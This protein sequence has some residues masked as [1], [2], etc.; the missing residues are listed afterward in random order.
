M[1]SRSRSSAHGMTDR[2]DAP[3]AEVVSGCFSLA[4]SQE[5]R[6]SRDKIAAV[7]WG[8]SRCRTHTL[9]CSRL[10]PDFLSYHLDAH[11]GRTSHADCPTS[12]AAQIDRTA[13]H[14]GTTIIDPN[15]YR[16]AITRI[17]DSNSRAERKRPVR[18]CHRARIELLTGCCPASRELLTIIGSNLRLRGTL[19]AYKRA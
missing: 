7:W 19:Q 13:L 9:L 8:Q 6:Q 11:V 4:A 17:C 14:E 18:S 1:T 10:C 5:L 15:D 2:V 12:T 16:A 3:T